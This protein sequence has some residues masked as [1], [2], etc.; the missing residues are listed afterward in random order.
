MTPETW[1]RVECLFQEALLRPV[2]ERT[3]FLHRSCGDVRLR[4][5]VESLLAAD[6][7]ADEVPDPP[8]D[9][10]EPVA[11]DAIGAYRVVR[12]L[13]EGGMS[14]VWLVERTD[15]VLAARLALKLI[16][17][18]VRSG[19]LRQRFDRERRILAALDHPHVARLLDAGS[20]A[21]GQ[22][23]FVMEHVAGV[24]LDQYCEDR[25]LG[26]EARLS[27]FRQVCD[28][29]HCAHRALVVHR[30]L[31]P[32]N[33]LVTADGV[34]KLLDFGIAKLID[35]GEAAADETG[36]AL[37]F[38][39]PHYASPEQVR[40]DVVTTATDVYSLGVVLYQL[41]CGRRPYEITTRSLAEIERVVCTFEPAAPSAV[42]PQQVRR[43]IRGDLDAIVLTALQKMPA[44]RYASA[45]ELSDDLDR[46]L[47]GQPVSARRATAA[48]RARKFLGRH[49]ATTVAAT[50]VA[51]SLLAGTGVAAWHARRARA[52]QRSAEAERARAERVSAFLV[53][54]F[55][56]ADPAAA[57]SG[58]VTARELLDRG[59]SRLGVELRDEPEVRA[60][61]QHA[62]GVVY[63]NLGYYRP[64]EALL[65][66][67]LATRRR[68]L[69]PSH[70]DVATS[71]EHLALLR[72]EV[73]GPGPV[74]LH[75]EALAV[76]R[77]ALGPEHPLVAESLHNLAL[78]LQHSDAPEVEG[79]H[80]EAL[81]IR[82]KVLGERDP[83]TAESLNTLAA[84][85]QAHDRY[86]EA[87]DMLAEV[88]AIR[89]GTLG[90]GHPSTLA[91]VNDIAIL[92]V[93]Q[94]RPAEAET[95]FRTAL[96]GLSRVYGAEH[97][98][99][100]DTQANLA[101]ALDILGRYEESLALQ[102]D[103]LARRRAARGAVH[104]AVDNSLNH[105]GA[106][107][108]HLG[109]DEEAE[110]ALLEAL[111]LRLTQW[112]ERHRSVAQTR[113]WLGL[114][115]LARG[116][117]EG[118]EREQR[119]SL[120][121]WRELLG[122]EHRGTAAALDGLA[123]AR[124]AQGD[125]HGARQLHERAL[126][127]RRRVLGPRHPLVADSL[128]AL[129]RLRQGADARSALRLAEEALAI[130]RAA[131]PAHPDTAEAAALVAACRLR[132]DGA[133]GS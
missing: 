29:V 81:G 94:G 63:R 106:V 47:Q 82:R 40:G 99:V 98:E 10:D 78:S 16:R 76:R 3:S 84:W 129:A 123:R 64:A 28:A 92:R 58:D 131:M 85:L 41:L 124:S 111:D 7:A 52:E 77:R 89:T 20:T 104:P 8:S 14:T 105:L 122:D 113:T 69:G 35:A 59:A 93:L 71:L 97:P 2:A 121:T 107:L 54:L 44:R 57:A 6:A 51:L 72:H 1:G 26:I 61:L 24:P 50:T 70:P 109:R 127:V 22:P 33:V 11:G 88:R 95:M 117:A 13:G 110:A 112:G 96:A 100:A 56:S 32:T 49:L 126:G 5:E 9:P 42:G 34:P 91:T 55:S 73:S 116:D 65:S 30:D 114:V 74:S 75:R 48:Y 43:R 67:A 128:E 12:K 25:G 23:Y 125:F 130:R 27:L 17:N 132:V 79:L 60:A 4:S 21:E 39:T 102:S 46:Y 15:G 103:A 118:A 62:I 53:D 120:A 66:E 45:R 38:W 18:G 90:A 19:A 119:R 80:R 133:T 31:K 68:V 108:L 115:R 86:R 83:A 36:A 101:F 87:D 37:R